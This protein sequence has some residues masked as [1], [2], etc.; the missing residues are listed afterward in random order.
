[1]SSGELDSHDLLEKA[2]RIVLIERASS[3]S[4]GLPVPLLR[5]SGTLSRPDEILPEPTVRACPPVDS[6]IAILHDPPSVGPDPAFVQRLVNMDASRQRMIGKNKAQE[7][8][9][10]IRIV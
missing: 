9:S 7:S 4:I 8:N 3:A 5:S 10:R 6:H 2:E 1:M